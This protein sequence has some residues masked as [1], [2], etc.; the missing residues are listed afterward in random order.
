MTFLGET[1]HP[2]GMGCWP[3]GGA[4]YAGE[5]SLGYTRTSDAQSLRTIHAALDLGITLFDTAAAYGAGHSERLLGQA[6]RDRPD[7]LVVTKIGIAVDEDTR[8]IT[9]GDTSPDR[10]LPAIDDCLTRLVRDRIDVVLLHANALPVDE[11]RPIFDQLDIARQSGKIRAYGW[12]TDFSASAA[13][14][15]DRD[16]FTAVEH[17]MNVFVAPPRIQAVTRDHGLAA[18]VRSPLAMGLLTGKYDTRTKMRSG[19]IRASNVMVIKY[20]QDGRPNPEFIA[21]LNAVRDL[22]STGGRTL[23]QGALGWLWAKG[24]HVIPIPGARTEEQITGLASALR[25]G[26]SPA[27]VM[28][29]IETLIDRDPPDAPE[30]EL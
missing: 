1:I 17:A 14:F 24:E 16:G 30:R 18:L 5:Q 6:L 21:R 7:A 13:A 9:F 22:L 29:A 11:A 28:E 12:S 3:I 4:M 20:F 25:H 10:V 26:P 2:L 15:A 23:I 8:Q 19:D 27:H